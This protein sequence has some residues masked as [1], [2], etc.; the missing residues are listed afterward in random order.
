MIMSTIY[1]RLKA[2][3]IALPDVQPP[4]V[5]G[6]VAAFVPFVR[7][8]NVVYLSG[9]LAKKHG[10]PW[11]GKLWEHIT[12]EEGKQAARGVAIEL[13]ATLQAAVGDLNKI[14][15]I[16]KLVVLVNSAPHFTEPHLVANGASELF[17]KS[18]ASAERMPAAPL[19]SRRFRLVAALRSKWSQRPSEK[20]VALPSIAN[21]AFPNRCN[22]D[23]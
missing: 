15:R 3:Q 16:V 23:S 2:L 19:V 7:T 6:Y 20:R 12:T 22:L 9:R 21:S 4:V 13:L 5:D 10:K 11:S 8:G 18:L 14:T 1:E 17:W